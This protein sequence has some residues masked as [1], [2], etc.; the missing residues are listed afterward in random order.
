MGNKAGQNGAAQGR[1]KA[2]CQRDPKSIREVLVM[3]MP[4]QVHTLNSDGEIPSPEA[5]VEAEAPLDPSPASHNPSNDRRSIKAILR[6][7]TRCFAPH[8]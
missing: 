5:Q 8:G 2:R 3:M 7:C 6:L 1:N 4:R